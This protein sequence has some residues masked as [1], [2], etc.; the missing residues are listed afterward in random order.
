MELNHLRTF[1][2]VAKEG[3]LTRASQRLFMTPPAVSAHIKQLEEELSVI[4]FER[5]PKGM[6][7]TEKGHLLKKKAEKTLQ[8]AQD[9]VNHA[10][11]LNECLM[12]SLTLALNTSP[13][14][15][16]IPTFV[17]KLQENAEGVSLSF[18]ESVTGHI[19][20]QL[21]RKEVDAG[22]VY[23]D[24]DTSIFSVQKLTRKTLVLAYPK[25]WTFQ[26][27]RFKSFEA[28]PWIVSDIYCPFEEMTSDLFKQ[29]NIQPKK[30]ITAN[31]ESTK[32]SLV[33]NGLGCAILEYDLVKSNANISY[34]FSFEIDLAFIYLKE[35]VNDPLIR[36]CV[37][38]LNTLWK[39]K[40]E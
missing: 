24:V 16:S 12:G 15:L 33:E 30:L 32:L 27:I 19:L 22:F 6:E 14:L 1:I 29:Y 2:A 34:Q 13:S 18:T 5:T 23:G 31:Q 40:G 20:N 7:L 38:C 9:L 37:E 4:L 17:S 36:V 8:S 26:E 39:Q 25:K 11:E 28:Y 3:N 35:R 21:S 10:T